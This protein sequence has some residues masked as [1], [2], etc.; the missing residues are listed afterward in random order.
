MPS[1]RNENYRMLLVARRCREFLIDTAPFMIEPCNSLSFRF[2]CAIKKS[3][4]WRLVTILLHRFVRK[5]VIPRVVPHQ[6]RLRAYILLEKSG[7]L[8]IV[9]QPEMRNHFVG[10]FR[11]AHAE[12]FSRLHLP[13]ELLNEVLALAGRDRFGSIPQ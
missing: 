2:P 5:E 6:V 10:E 8:G 7:L 1:W 13:S 4:N 3:Q 12:A 9:L 11:P